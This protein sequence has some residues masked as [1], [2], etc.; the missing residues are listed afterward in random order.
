MFVTLKCFRSSDFNINPKITQVGWFYFLRGKKNNCNQV[1]VITGRV[2]H[3]PVEE[4][5][6]T[7]LCRTDSVQLCWRV[8]EMLLL[9]CQMLQ[10]THLRRSSTFVSPQNIFPKVVFIKMFLGKTETSLCISFLLSSGF[11]LGSLPSCHFCLV[12]FLQPSHEHWP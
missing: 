3:F 7:L 12:S 11:L 4:F 9:L 6:T 1:F 2:F 10:G 5:W 8:S